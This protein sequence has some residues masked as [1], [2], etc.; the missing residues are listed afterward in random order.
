[1]SQGQH[2]S[3][4][5]NLGGPL[6][7]LHH[8]GN[9]MNRKTLMI[10]QE[11][12]SALFRGKSVQGSINLARD[13][14][15]QCRSIRGRSQVT[16]RI[17][18]VCVLIEGFPRGPCLASAIIQTE[19]DKNTINPSVEAGSPIK[20]LQMGIGAQECLLGEVLGLL[21]IPGEIK[22]DAVGLLLVPFHQVFKC[23]GIPPPGPRLRDLY[24]PALQ[25]DSSLWK[26][27]S[28]L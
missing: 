26:S 5:V 20:A 10:F 14:A 1:M 6:S 2:G 15:C 3:V 24:P 9:F 25:E 7:G 13:F 23:V 21:T 4:E 28:R 18:S 11:K 17:G 27:Q 12:G 22:R 19:V 16:P 8:L